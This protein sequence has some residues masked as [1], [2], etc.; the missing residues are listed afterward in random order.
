[1][2]D[3]ETLDDELARSE[4]AV[5]HLRPGCQK[6]VVWAGAP[7][8]KTALCVVFLHGFSASSGELRPLPDLVA[9]GLNAN[10]YFTRLTGHGQDGAAMA[11]AEFSDWTRDT[12]EALEIAAVLGDETLVIGCSTGCTLAALALTKGAKLK[13]LVQV[14]PNYGLAHKAAQAVLDAP[15]SR[16]WGHILAGK[17]RHFEP[18]SAEHAQFWTTTYPSTAAAPMGEAVRTAKAAPLEDIMTPTLMAFNDADQVVCAKTTRQIMTRWG[19]PVTHVSLQQ[20]PDDD[21][22]GHIMAGDVFSP[23]QTGPLARRILDWVQSL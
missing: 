18:I 1:M 20:G 11:D 3:I 16:H 9:N 4:A 12:D 7:A 2:F 6:Q 23:R 5:P 8:T 17:T 14:S 15:F 13:G 21:A 22:M 19:G 10:L